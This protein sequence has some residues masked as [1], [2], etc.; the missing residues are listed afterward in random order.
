MVGGH[1]AAHSVGGDKMA[2][3]RLDVAWFDMG[4]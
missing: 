1:H 2:R 3:Q 4:V